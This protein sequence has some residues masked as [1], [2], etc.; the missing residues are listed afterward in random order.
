MIPLKSRNL[1]CN[2]EAILLIANYYRK[3]HDWGQFIA[4][5]NYVSLN[6]GGFESGAKYIP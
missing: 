3:L 1:L 2:K 6:E 4:E 5:S